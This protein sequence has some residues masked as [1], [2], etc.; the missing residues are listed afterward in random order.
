M[1]AEKEIKKA[2]RKEARKVARE[3]MI[4][5]AK[6]IRAS[7]T[8]EQIKII[9]KINQQQRKFKEMLAHYGKF[10]CIICDL[11]IEDRN[12]CI[13]CQK[14]SSNFSPEDFGDY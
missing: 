8:P 1:D 12:I 2:E 11:K 6:K 3:E 7:W 5:K 4:E 14:E 13:E 9:K 10:L